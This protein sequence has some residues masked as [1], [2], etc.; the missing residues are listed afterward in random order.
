MA[1]PISAIAF[2]VLL[3]L[4]DSERHGYDI[5]RDVE[6][7]SG[8]TV[9]PGTLYRTIR[10]LT[11]DGLLTELDERPAPELDDERRRYYAVN[12]DGRECARREAERLA[13]L[14]A[15]ARAKNLLGRSKA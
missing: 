14:V 15:A 3:S 4:L 2:E 5:M 10:R 8:Q 11:D 12:P 1:R 7:R 13:E 9:H 6:R